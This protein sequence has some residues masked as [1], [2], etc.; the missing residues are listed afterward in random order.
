MKHRFAFCF[1]NALVVLFGLS[2]CSTAF[3]QSQT[4]PCYKSGKG[5]E[6]TITLQGKDL[7][8]LT[9]LNITVGSNAAP[10]PNYLTSFGSPGVHPS[11]PG[12][13]TVTVLIP[14]NAENGSY[15]LTDITASGDGFSLDYRP[16]TDFTAPAPF[17][18]CILKPF[19]KPSIK[20]ITEKP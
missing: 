20:S 17:E 11:S 7:S 6:Y 13:F 10:M 18:V 19:E 15:F 5:P 8:A 12:V 1:T 9:N 4:K 3:G 14:A 16:G 2:I